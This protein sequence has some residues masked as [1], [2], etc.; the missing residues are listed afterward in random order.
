M[1]EEAHCLVRH[2]SYARPQPLHVGGFGFLGDDAKRSTQEALDPNIREKA[3]G[4]LNRGRLFR[5]GDVVS[6]ALEGPRR[7]AVGD[8]DAAVVGGIGD[9]AELIGR[10]LGH[11]HEVLL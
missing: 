5:V 4:A 1:G 6:R 7:L 10:G 9:V 2:L 11:V 8:S 3:R